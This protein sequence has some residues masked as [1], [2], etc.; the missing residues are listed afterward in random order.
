MG[1]I[2]SLPGPSGRKDHVHDLRQCSGGSQ[3]LAYANRVRRSSPARIA[4]LPRSRP[5]TKAKTCSYPCTASPA[6]SPPA[7]RVRA[8]SAIFHGPLCV[9]PPLRRTFL[10]TLDGNGELIVALPVAELGPGIIGRSRAVQAV[11]IDSQ[12]LGWVSGPVVMTLLDAGI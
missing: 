6:T 1:G 5:R 9:A 3:G 2:V 4:P 11:L 12:G 10:D 8:P 7:S